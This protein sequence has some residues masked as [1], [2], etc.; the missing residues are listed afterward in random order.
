MQKVVH[1]ELPFDDAGR[2]EKFYKDAFE[3]QIMT[4]PM[5]Q[6]GNYYMVNT[7]DVD[8]QQM[9]KEAGAINGGLSARDATLQAPV[10]VVKV[11]EMNAALEKV[12]ASGGSVVMETTT[13]M[14]MGLYARIKDTEGNIIGVWQDLPR[15]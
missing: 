9:P 8:E 12:K 14:D 10:I 4:M 6:G 7:V 11:P 15:Q 5:P 3:W 2:A 13:V 1:F